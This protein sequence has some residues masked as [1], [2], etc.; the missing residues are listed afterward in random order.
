L[1]EAIGMHCTAYVILLGYWFVGK[2]SSKVTC[3]LADWLIRDLSFL[4]NIYSNCDGK[5]V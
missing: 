2:L 3:Q 4:C 1:H 5:F